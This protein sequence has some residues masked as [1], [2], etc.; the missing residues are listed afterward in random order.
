MNQIDIANIRRASDYIRYLS[1]ESIEKAKSGHPGLPL[2]CAD[3]GVV[4]YRYILTHMPED[5]QWIN[6]DRFVLSA[7][8]GSMLLYSLL[9]LAGYD[10]SLDDID[11]FRQIGSRTPGHPEFEKELGIETT[12]GPLGQGFANTVGMAIEGKILAD[13]F[14]E[15]DID[16]FDYTIFTLM[17]DGCM[18][19]G[20]SYEAA[21]MAGHLG[22]DNIVAIYDSNRISID[23]ST[24]ITFSE[25]VGKRFEAMG[26]DVDA[27]DIKD[28]D[29]LYNKL[30]TLKK[31]KGKPKLLIVNTIIGAGLDKKKDTSGIHGAPAG[32]AEISYFIKNSEVLELFE[33][34]YG[35]DVVEDGD[36]LSQILE[37][38]AKDREPMLQSRDA[39]DFMRQHIEENNKIYTAWKDLLEKYKK[40]FPSKYEELDKIL[41]FKL[42]EDLEQTLL[43]YKEE[44]Q[45]ATRG[46]AGRVL[47]ICAEKIPQMIGGCADLAGSTKAG[48]K[49]SQYLTKEDFSGRNIAFGI[50]EHA[51][52]SVGNGLALNDS[53][54]P[55]TSTF[56]TFFDYMKPSV[57]LAAL[58]K[59]NHLF[60]FSHDSIY[61]GEDGPTHQPI[62]HL[63]S[64]RLI[65]DLVT[66]RPG[67]DTETAFAFLYFLDKL[68]GPAAIIT[69]R[70]KFH[71][72]VF[73][74]QLNNK[75]KYGE[76]SKGA[77]IFHQTKEDKHPDLILAASG[78]ELGLALETAK[79]LEE[80]RDM[81]VRV[82][83][84]PCMELFSAAG[85]EY[86][87]KIMDS[88]QA[89][90]V[91][92][93][94]ASHRAVDIFYDRNILTIDIQSFGV[95]APGNTVGD[96]FGFTSQKVLE[97]IDEI[98]L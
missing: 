38:R 85:P 98:I 16:L 35:A 83:S 65:P 91:F 31:Q 87:E 76:F 4:L 84:I 61:V 53:I 24:D 40:N 54:I 29:S 64:L 67:N 22:L 66:F 7:G 90:V 49:G 30:D 39:A 95:S 26:W 9:H 18:M 41:N 45:D 44:K 1:L 10:I 48:V 75:E 32:T 36:K 60:I 23:G 6:R 74:H 34:K 77:Y 63:N 43:T 88:K 89:P 25:D 8:H 73:E 92:I 2:G 93:E 72:S 14:N 19:E 71:T 17:G 86:R 68:N 80:K 3:L 12:T 57:R 81:N 46:I 50:R 42:P 56:F 27:C 33:N 28:L 62:E 20:V 69:S 55:F 52:G 97:K 47:N 59:L 82:V 96:H 94:A 37:A 58:M 15:R 70:Q 5:P 21:S 11:Q 51:M 13:R 78:S 79:K